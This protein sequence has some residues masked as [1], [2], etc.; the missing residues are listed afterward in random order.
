M[1][2]ALIE[3]GTLTANVDER[4]VS[5]RLLAFGEV[6]RTNLGRFTVGKGV[7]RLPKDPRFVGLDLG[8]D[9]MKPLGPGLFAH[10]ADDGIYAA[11]RIEDTPEGNALLAQ[12]AGGDDSAPRKLSIEVDDVVI[13][14]GQ[15]VSGTVHGAGVVQAGAFPSA[16]LMAEDTPEPKP[17]GAPALI[18]TGVKMP[19]PIAPAA[20]EAVEGRPATLEEINALFAEL[21]QT[22][23]AAQ[24]EQGGGQQAQ[25]PGM[26]EMFT[27]LAAARR[28]DGH[29]EQARTLLAALTDITAG[30]NGSLDT[31]GA[32]ASQTSAIQ[33]KWLGQLWQGIAYV[34]RYIP[35]LGGSGSI[36]SMQ[37][38]GFTVAAGTE[39]VQPWAGNKTAISS[40]GGTTALKNST[41]QRW[42]WA[43][44]IAR[45]WFDIPGNEE[46]ISAF[47]KLVGQSYSRVT[48]KWTL[49]QLVAS[50]TTVAPDTYPTLDATRDYPTAI[51]Q[52][53]QG[54]D[55]VSADPVDDTPA[56]AVCNAAAWQEIIY[57]P[58]DALPQWMT[59]N[60]GIQSQGGTADDGKVHVVRG[61]IGI[62]NT[63]AVMVGSQASAHVN[64]LG[65][66][67]NPLNISAIDLVN[68]GIDQA[69]IGYTQFLA[70]YADALVIV[71]TAD[72]A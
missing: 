9:R 30:T 53:I 45:E 62:E 36:V 5:G 55:Y 34:R 27:L 28:E 69:R 11:W 50:A 1:T 43:A 58:A 25:E 13:R 41:L 16:T 21:P 40:A 60:F 72:E 37:E 22:L 3:A 66:P 33:K 32:G 20:D 4:T 39:L 57:A 56:F 14:N 24:Q 19:D 38:Q 42:G 29:G 7:F 70:D 63:S 15:A 61:D 31:Q 17:N 2:Q 65:G 23:L 44:D 35:L 51:K 52:L 48:D 54:V 46:V 6:G 71:G 68:G 47:L 8:H 12:Y 10:E 49:A 64:E 67:D 26:N 18:K 59:L